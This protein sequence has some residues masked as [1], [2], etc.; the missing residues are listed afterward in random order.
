MVILHAIVIGALEN[1]FQFVL[2]VLAIEV[3]LDASG[4][5]LLYDEAKSL[6]QVSDLLFEL[7]YLTWLVSTVSMP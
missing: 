2:A 7:M 5:R 4:A 1:W 6:L 3:E